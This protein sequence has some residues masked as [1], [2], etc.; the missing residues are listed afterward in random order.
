MD[1]FNVFRA[2][3]F[4]ILFSLPL[5]ALIVLAIVKAWFS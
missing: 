2:L 4:G 1:G 3:L 5:W